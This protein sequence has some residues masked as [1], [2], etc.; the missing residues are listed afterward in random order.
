MIEIEKRGILTFTKYKEIKNILDKEARFNKEFK[1]FSLISVANPDFT[2]GIDKEIDIRLRTTG[3]KGMFTV[4]SG[5][6]HKDASRGE[7]EVE[8]NT[9]DIGN[10]VNILILQDH[11]QFIMTYIHRLEYKLEDFTV[12]IDKYFSMDAYIFE[13]ELSADEKVDLHEKEDEVAKLFDKYKLIPMSSDDTI[14]FITEV[15]NVK[16]MRVDFSKTN[17][18]VWIKKYTDL[19]YCKA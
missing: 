4:K 9:T 17:V 5:N 1:R 14:K 2:P 6:W 3:S 15:N 10:L 11:L 12:T 13:A 16:G 7:Y 8:F 19:I 18:D